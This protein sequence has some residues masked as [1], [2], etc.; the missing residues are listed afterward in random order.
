MILCALT[1]V[2]WGVSEYLAVRVLARA[3]IFLCSIDLADQ[4]TD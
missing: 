3:C 1:L 2:R 4:L